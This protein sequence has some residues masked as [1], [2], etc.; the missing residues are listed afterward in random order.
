MSIAS[1]LPEEAIAKGR[2]SAGL[3]ALDPLS[4]TLQDYRAEQQAKTRQ[5][6]AEAEQKQSAL[7]APDGDRPTHLMEAQL[8]R[9][10]TSGEIIKRLKRLNPNLLFER[11]IADPSI[12]GIYVAEKNEYGRRHLFGFEFGYSPE[13]SV[14]T[15]DAEGRF[16]EVRGWRTVLAR[17]IRTRMI[18]KEAAENAF[19]IPTLDSKNWQTL[20]T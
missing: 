6:V 4:R 9:P 7:V 2:V 8:G 20:T 10:M 12:M 3:P 11:S 16:R 18:S 13:Y 5:M 1:L 15:T 14:R 17:L 19:G